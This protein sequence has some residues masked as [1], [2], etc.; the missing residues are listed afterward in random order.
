[1]VPGFYADAAS[2]AWKTVQDGAEA[3]TAVV[4]EFEGEIN[5]VDNPTKNRLAGVPGGVAFEKLFD[6]GGLLAPGLGGVGW[7]KN[8]IHGMEQ[9]TPD[10]ASAAGG[11]LA[12]A[13]EIVNIYVDLGEGWGT[14]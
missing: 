2:V 3:V 4:R 14:R 1:L 9:S 12:E 6:G 8:L 5:R 13:N 10:P 7:P 11:S